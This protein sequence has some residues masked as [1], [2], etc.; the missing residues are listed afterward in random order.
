MNPINPIL[1]KV[2]AIFVVVSDIHKARE[3][4]CGILGLEPVF[5]IIAGHLCCIPLNNDGQNLVL[6]SKIYTDDTFARTPMFHFN[7]EDIQAAFQFMKDKGVELAS[8]IEHGHYFNFK[9][10]DG[11][12][13]MVCKC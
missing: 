2:S 6:D 3:W 1:N 8:D 5:E 4:Y 11:N 7:T 12:M 10:P 9:D 13:L